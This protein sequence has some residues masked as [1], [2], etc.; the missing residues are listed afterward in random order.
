MRKALPINIVIC[1]LICIIIIVCEVFFANSIINTV[2]LSI[3]F[4]APLGMVIITILELSFHKKDQRYTHIIN[5]IKFDIFFI[6]ALLSLVI[7][8]A[9]AFGVTLQ[10]GLTEIIAGLA[11]LVALDRV[12]IYAKIAFEKKPSENQ[13]DKESK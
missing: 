7:E 13:I 2:L 5:I 6:L 9:K 12:L 4:C 10:I 3:Y 8:S 1:T 11:T